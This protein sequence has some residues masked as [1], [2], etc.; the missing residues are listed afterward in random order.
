[1]DFD[2][3]L[4]TGATWCLVLGGVWSVLV[5][6]AAVV[7]VVSDGRLALT[8]RLGCPT[9]LRRILLTGVGVVLA[10]SGAVVTVPVAAAPGPLSPDPDGASAGLPVP[11]RP[12]GA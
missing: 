3:L 8:R 11:D 12:T 10:G 5:L 9:P 4:L 7:E 1:M 6:S 2:E